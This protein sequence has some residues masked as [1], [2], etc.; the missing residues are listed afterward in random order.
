[1]GYRCRDKI[2]G[3]VSEYGAGYGAEYEG[4]GG[5]WL[6]IEDRRGKSLARLGSQHPSSC[7]ASSEGTIRGR[8]DLLSTWRSGRG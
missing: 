2:Q 1:M 5:G 3:Q 6:G 4:R 7:G 8:L